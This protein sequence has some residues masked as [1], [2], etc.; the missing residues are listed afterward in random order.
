MV[1]LIEILEQK[2]KLLHYEMMGYSV[3]MLQKLKIF[4]SYQNFWI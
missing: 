1:L 2:Q 4:S 3:L